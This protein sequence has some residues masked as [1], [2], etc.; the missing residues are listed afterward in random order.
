[1]TYKLIDYERLKAFS[2]GLKTK[3]ATK[4]EF[5]SQME[6]ISVSMSDI[7]SILRQDMKRKIDKT[8]ITDNF[9]EQSQD[10]VLS[11]KG[12]NDL[13]RNTGELYAS[14]INGINAQL[15]LKANNT[16]IPTKLSQLTNDKTFKTEAEIQSM[17]EK[18]SSL[19][20][21]VVTSLPTT[22]KDD[23]IYLVKDSDGKDNNNYLEYLWLNGKYELIGSTQVDLSGYAQ[24]TDI[25]A[26]KVIS[27][28][29]L[30]KDFQDALQND[31]DFLT[32][33]KR[34]M[35]TLVA[36]KGNNAENLMGKA[37]FETILYY[38]GQPV[39]VVD[40]VG[41]AYSGMDKT[42]REDK[43]PKDGS[44]INWTVL[45]AYNSTIQAQLKEQKE[46]ALDKIND[47]AVASQ[48]PRP[49]SFEW[50][51]DDK[52]V[53]P[54]FMSG[55]FNFVLENIANLI[56][57]DL[58]KKVNTSDIQEFTQQELEEAFK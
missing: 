2:E 48:N 7:N 20:K 37:G 47:K 23:V 6:N 57:E 40:I 34:D 39:G 45:S 26:S 56:Q 44:V 14:V 51:N 9:E 16:D 53:T 10:K 27:V 38:K 19:K 1:M 22:G 25:T 11:Q 29:E 18:A 3:Y 33:I 36:F 15:F 32:A 50:K 17:I 12:A 24:L 5:N 13:Y 28:Y 52:Y 35:L 54:K 21:E 58:D 41:N 43:M 55:Y 31:Q 4:S 42:I 30:D 46:N 8:D 49:D